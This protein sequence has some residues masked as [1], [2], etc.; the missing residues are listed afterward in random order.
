MNCDL[1]ADNSVVPVE[2]VVIFSVADVIVEDVVGAVKV[3]A[4]FA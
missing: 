3:L 1:G 2:D 4:T